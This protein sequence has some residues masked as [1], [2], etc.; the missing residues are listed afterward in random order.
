MR[1]VPPPAQVAA[2]EKK[3]TLR[4]PRLPAGEASETS[5][6]S[7]VEASTSH[8]EALAH[9]RSLP[10]L[11]SQKP[12]KKKVH[13]VEE[14]LT[15][16]SQIC[17]EE[18][19]RPT[20]VGCHNWSPNTSGNYFLSLGEKA[21]PV[22]PDNSETVPQGDS[23]VQHIGPA[24]LGESELVESLQCL[25]N[26]IELARTLPYE[27]MVRSPTRS[28]TRPLSNCSLKSFQGPVEVFSPGSSFSRGMFA[29]VLEEVAG[30]MMLKIRASELSTD[31][32]STVQS[33][34]G[35]ADDEGRIL[36]A[37]EELEVGSNDRQTGNN[38]QDFGA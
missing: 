2:R 19:D 5:G 34:R 9:A 22:M 35:E 37:H 30:E 38:G 3:K 31:A 12:K 27:E 1:K 29:D 13:I 20:M 7:V 18:A 16:G 24:T 25:V 8:H 26:D 6:P 21:F 23:A 33:F 4:L 32:T 28:P 36:S 17:G 10:T 15:Q 11:P 14:E